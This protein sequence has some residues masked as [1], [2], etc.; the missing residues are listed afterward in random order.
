MIWQDVEVFWIAKITFSKRRNGVKIWQK[1][2]FIEVKSRISEIHLQQHIHDTG[3][4]RLKNDH[5]VLYNHDLTFYEVK[6]RNEMSL[7]LGENQHFIKKIIH[8]FCNRT[9]K[10]F[11]MY[12]F[13][14]VFIYLVLNLMLHYSYPVVF[15]YETCKIFSFFALVRKKI[16]KRRLFKKVQAFCEEK[17]LRYLLDVFWYAESKNQCWQA[18]KWRL[19]YLICIFPR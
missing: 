19:H 11:T 4:E 18:E 16:R 8:F 9:G 14:F 2:H 7:F 13:F 15:T 3:R 1:L 12:S 6:V 5:L 17:V 10:V